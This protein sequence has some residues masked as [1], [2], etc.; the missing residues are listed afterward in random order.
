MGRAHHRRRPD[1]LSQ[2]GHRRDQLDAPR[3]EEHADELGHEGRGVGRRPELRALNKRGVL[4]FNG[5]VNESTALEGLVALLYLQ[6]LSHQRALA[7]RL[8]VKA[9]SGS[10]L[11]DCYKMYPYYV[12]LAPA[13]STSGAHLAP[14]RRLSYPVVWAHPGVLSYPGVWAYPGAF[15]FGR[16]VRSCVRLEMSEGDRAR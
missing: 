4:N 5:P 3:D 10:F 15:A 6:I 14:C 12:V 11:W 13:A 7:L 2:H 8:Q 9:G 16:E 1:V